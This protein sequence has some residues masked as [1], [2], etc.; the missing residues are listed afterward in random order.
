MN[1]DVSSVNS[2]SFSF[3]SA[4]TSPLK[5]ES[6]SNGLAAT[7]SRETRNARSVTPSPS[8]VM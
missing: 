5:L 7:C 8:S 6:T 3:S 4:I 1:C 2:A